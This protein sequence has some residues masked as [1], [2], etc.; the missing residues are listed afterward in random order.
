MPASCLGPHPPGSTAYLGN[1]KLIV[2]G[3]VVHIQLEVDALQLFAAKT[4]DTGEGDCRATKQKQQRASLPKGRG[5]VPKVGQMGASTPC[6]W[7][8]D[9][10]Q[11]APTWPWTVGDTRAGWASG[12][13]GAGG[14]AEGLESLF[15]GR[16]KLGVSLEK[17]KAMPRGHPGSEGSGRVRKQVAWGPSEQRSA[18]RGRDTPTMEGLPAGFPRSHR[19][20]CS[21]LPPVCA[22][23]QSTGPQGEGTG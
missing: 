21:N 12:P 14:G 8:R 3:R 16:R 23:G 22:P 1:R 2:E 7:S 15:V 4:Q 5:A 17:P 10:T 13:G 19:P 6:L 11:P 9:P 18:Q 20:A